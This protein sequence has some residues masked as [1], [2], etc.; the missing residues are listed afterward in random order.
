MRSL[1][2]SKASLVLPDPPAPVSVN[3]RVMARW[4]LISIISCS[5]PTKLDLE[6]GKLCLPMSDGSSVGAT[7]GRDGNRELI[8][9][10]VDAA[11][12]DDLGPYCIHL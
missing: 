11:A 7:V 8:R 4:R 2:T 12:S 10:E 6:A 3:R 9:E 1:A 5:R